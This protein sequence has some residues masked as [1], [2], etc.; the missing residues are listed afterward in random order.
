MILQFQGYLIPLVF[1]LSHPPPPVLHPSH[2][3][4]PLPPVPCHLS[5]AT[6]PLPPV[7][8]PPF[9]CHL[10]FTH[11]APPVPC[12]LSF[13]HHLPPVPPR[14]FQTDGDLRLA[15]MLLLGVEQEDNFWHFYSDY[16]PPPEDCPSL[17]LATEVGGGNANANICY[18][19]SRHRE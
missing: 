19:I 16:L 13:T 10:L 18:V 11:H 2:A 1:V 15:C 6:C 9:P 7:P 17:L 5:P 4:C 14:V 8:C 3:T 12:H